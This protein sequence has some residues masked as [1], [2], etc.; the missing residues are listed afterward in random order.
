MTKINVLGTDY[1]FQEDDLNNELLAEN[2]GVCELYEKE[3]VV[4]KREYMPGSTEV[5]RGNRYQHVILHELVHAFA[6]E[7]G[8]SYGN[9]EALVDWIAH[10]I[11]LINK[12]HSKI[13]AGE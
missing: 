6:E 7:S 2:D 3:I 13:V 12:A 5:G 11:P 4:R 9:D 8:V 1:V 10:M